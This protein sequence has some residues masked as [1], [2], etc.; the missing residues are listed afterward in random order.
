MGRETLGRQ[1]GAAQACAEEFVADDV[2]DSGAVSLAEA[3]LLI[4]KLCSRCELDLPREAKVEELLS[5]CDKSGD[6]EL[7]LNEFQN[8]FR[9]IVESACKK[10]RADLA[11]AEAN[12]AASS[13]RTDAPVLPADVKAGDQ[14]K[15]AASSPREKPS[16]PASPTPTPKAAANKA[17]TKAAAKSKAAKRT[18]R[19]ERGSG[20]EAVAEHSPAANATA[21]VTTSPPRRGTSIAAT[22]GLGVKPGMSSSSCCVSGSCLPR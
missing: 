10:A 16:S 15:H 3:K 7:Q 22:R 19:A 14:Q 8:F 21:S 2:D 13:P 20:K 11:A 17:A 6:G 5:L 18:H 9:A 12:K 1:G 4:A